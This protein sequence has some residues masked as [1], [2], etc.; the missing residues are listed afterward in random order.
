MMRRLRRIVSALLPAVLALAVPLLF[1]CCAPGWLPDSSGFVFV[2]LNG[3]FLYKVEERTTTRIVS[4]QVALGFQPAAWP[5]GDQVV[6]ATVS[7][8]GEQFNL[9]LK[10]VNLQGETTHESPVH[11][12][13]TDSK[14]AAIVCQTFASSDERHV[15]TYV[16]G[17]N[18]IIA[19]D[20]Q[21]KTFRQFDK[22]MPLTIPPRHEKFLFATT[23][24]LPDGSAFIAYHEGEANKEHAVRMYKWNEEVP[25]FFEGFDTV[26]E[27]GLSSP[28]SPVTGVITEFHWRDAKLMLRTSRGL[29]SI[30][31]AARRVT[32]TQDERTDELRRHAEN[33][34]V[35]VISELADGSLLQLTEDRQVQLW[36]PADGGQTSQF[37]KIG[38]EEFLMI[39][40]SPNRRWATARAMV[41][42]SSLTLINSL[43]GETRKIAAPKQ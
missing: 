6:L 9:Q 15:L 20:K 42:N 29:V 12:I 41:P 13:V 28:K 40:V 26:D 25:Q 11:R 37:A 10:F 19:Y 4:Q 31:P 5:S 16:F 14:D 22:V 35:V 8:G 18:T 32:L 34:K 30:D 21:Q 27:F 1:V 3:V 23:P 7:R 33:E 39:A 24:I 43:T 38:A 2:D 17:T 36:R